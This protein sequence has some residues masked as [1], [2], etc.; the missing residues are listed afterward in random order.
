MIVI[1]CFLLYSLHY[2][3]ALCIMITAFVNDTLEV[4][5]RSADSE[6]EDNCK[7]FPFFTVFDPEFKNLNLSI[8]KNSDSNSSVSRDNIRLLL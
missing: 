8:S 6:L 3:L 2:C 7:L 5:M 1:D 4:K